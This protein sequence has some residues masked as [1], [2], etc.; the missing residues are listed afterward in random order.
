MNRLRSKTDI[1]EACARNLYGNFFSARNLR[2]CRIM[3]GVYVGDT[4]TLFIVY[5]HER[6]VVMR[7][8]ADGNPN[9][10]PAYGGH[11]TL[12]EARAEARRMVREDREVDA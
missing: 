7:V 5:R 2:H 1:R 4:E 3:S 12:S 6:Y 8:D 9:H 11:A 10:D